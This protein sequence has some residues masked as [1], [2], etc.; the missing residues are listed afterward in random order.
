MSP[1]EHVAQGAREGSQWQHQLAAAE[2][3]QESDDAGDMLG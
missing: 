2:V 1:A 3:F